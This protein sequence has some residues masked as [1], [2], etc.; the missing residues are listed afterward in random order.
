MLQ[1]RALPETCHADAPAIIWGPEHNRIH[2]RADCAFPHGAGSAGRSRLSAS[3]RPRPVAGVLYDL[4]G[5]LLDTAADIT[6]A[7]NRTFAEYGWRSMSEPEVRLM[8]GRGGQVLLERAASSQQRSLDASA[9]AAMVERF[10]QHYG[11]LEARNE[12]VAQPY[13]GVISTLQRLRQAGLRAAVVT[14]KQHRFA[15][16]LFERLQMAA[17]I[18]LVVGGD[19]C[20]RRKPDPQP[21]LYACQRLALPLTQTVVVGDSINDVLA[22]R[23]GG[24]SIVCVT[25]GYNEGQDPRAL[26]GDAWID[27]LSDLPAMLLPT[28]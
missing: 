27:S 12:S 18:D 13:P 7:L 9:L 28:A 15:V 20:E 17:W 19:T 16:E 21:L 14:N 11:A 6:L 22:A 8:I 25:Y 24:L 1:A 26:P 2:A 10:Y 23:A 5:T 3:W 4:D